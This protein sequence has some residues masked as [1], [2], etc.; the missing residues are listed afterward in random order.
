[1]GKPQGF[2][3]TFRL[4]RAADFQSVFRRSTRSGDAY[5]TVLARGNRLGIARLGLAIARK[6]LRRSVDRNR[7]KRL[8]RES[9]RRN[10]IALAG[11]DLVVISRPGIAD[12]A[13]REILFSLQ[14]HWERLNSQCKRS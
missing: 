14:G 4:V 1:L 8:V 11:L 5:F 13:N 6:H 3:R 2:T 9:F 12:P 10:R 7:I